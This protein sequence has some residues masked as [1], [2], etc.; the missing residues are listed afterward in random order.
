MTESAISSAVATRAMPVPGLFPESIGLQPLSP[1]WQAISAFALRDRPGMPAELLENPLLRV[2]ALAYRLQDVQRK[3]SGEPY[4]KH[5]MRT[6]M[7]AG[8][9][10]I[11]AGMPPADRR[12]LIAS[13]LLH[14]ALELQRKARNRYGKRQLRQDLLGAGVDPEETA[15]VV[16]IVTFLTP[17]VEGKN[18]R[19]EEDYL[20]YKVKDFKKKFVT[21]G[22]DS[23]LTRLIKTADLLANLE[24]TVADLQEGRADGNMGRSLGIRKLVF[25]AR[26]R[27]I[28]L[29]DPHNPF[30]PELFV[31]LQLLDCLMQ[32]HFSHQ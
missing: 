11:L 19:D 10:D 12:V 29:C 6:V 30:L 3:V 22:R 9:E 8:R 32:E 21:V 28:S 13:A 5:V 24:E 26:I 15:R 7:H 27:L 31:Q 2:T 4:F 18:I 25:A 16:R 17:P 1:E 20:R 23:K 14:D